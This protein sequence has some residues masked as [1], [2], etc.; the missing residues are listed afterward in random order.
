MVRRRG[1]IGMLTAAL[2]VMLLGLPAAAANARPGDGSSAADNAKT[3]KVQLLAINDFH[4]NIEP[5]FLRPTGDFIGGAEYLDTHL[6]I[7][8]DCT[9]VGGGEDVDA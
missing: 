9:D 8:V 3:T 5:P 6:T 1:R 7:A 4:G 2:G